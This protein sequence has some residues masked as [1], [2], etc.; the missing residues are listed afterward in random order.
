MEDW[1]H[2]GFGL[3]VHWP[4]CVSKCPY[5]DFN[6]HVSTNIDQDAWARAYLEAIDQ[7]AAETP[8]RALAS[9]YFGGGTPSLM[10]PDLVARIIERAQTK[11]HVAN[12][13]EIT[14]EANPNSV[15]VEKFRAYQQG[16]VNRVSLGVQAL[17]DADLRKLGRMH[18]A[19]EALAALAVARETFDRVSFDL[20]YARQD[21]TL[22][23]WQAEL[24]QALSFDPTH[25][26]LYQLT[27]EPG[28][29]FGT[30]AKAQ[31]LPG[32]PDEDLSA[33][34]FENTVKHCESKG[35]INYEVS[36]FA[37]DGFQSRHNGI[38]WNGGDYVGIGPG[39][40]GRLTL[41]GHRFATETALAPAVWLAGKAHRESLRT[42]LSR[43]DQATEYLIM[44]LRV[45]TGISLSR[46]EAMHGQPLSETTINDLGDQG[47]VQRS[48]DT[49]AVTA[50][51]VP[52]L[53]GIIRE[54]A[55][56]F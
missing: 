14:L 35:L 19:D 29:V 46:F 17:N 20:I 48:G 34:M 55:A 10:N 37:V 53:N 52:L 15:E 26:S 42:A 9:I 38:Y 41:N 3:Y 33:D 12:D 40:H 36:N 43:E 11:W 27:I 7:Y 39:A 1:Q 21:Q 16:G 8:G 51:G 44:G 28:T 45:K 30:R 6:S 13:V 23:A 5:C 24:E 50:K 54:L 47:L 56:S 18:S 22:A 32:L 31:K 25:L 2:G 4:F 49:L